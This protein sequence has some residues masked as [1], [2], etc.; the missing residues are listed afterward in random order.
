MPKVRISEVTCGKCNVV[1]V[2]A[3]GNCAQ[4]WMTEWFNC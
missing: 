1:E 2:C 4:K 3:I